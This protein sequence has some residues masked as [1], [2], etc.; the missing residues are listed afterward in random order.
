MTIKE[1]IKELST[2]DQDRKI[3]NGNFDYEWGDTD[4]FNLKI[5]EANDDYYSIEM[6]LGNDY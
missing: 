3:V 6:E 2:L 4:Y 5:Y 1:L